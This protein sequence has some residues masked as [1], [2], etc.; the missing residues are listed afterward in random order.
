MSMNQLLNSQGGLNSKMQSSPLMDMAAQLLGGGKHS[1]TQQSPSAGA[2]GIVGTLAE[3]LLGVKK[4]NQGPQQRYSWQSNS[5]QSYSG[6]SY[7]EPSYSGQSDSGQSNSGQSY[8]GQ[9]YSGQIPQGAYGLHQ[10]SLMS[11]LGGMFGGVY[12]NYLSHLK[13]QKC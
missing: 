13:Y 10:D 9:S 8:S 12:S 2:A 7:S 5:G 11:K 4:P 3:R 6:Q 1:P